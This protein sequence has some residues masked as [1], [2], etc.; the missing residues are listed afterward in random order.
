MIWRIEVAYKEW[1]E[2]PAGKRIKRRLVRDLHVDVT[3]VRIVDVYT[4]VGE[5]EDSVIELLRRDGF[6][7]PIVQ[8][9]YIN[10]PCPYI[11]DW[12]IEVGF[13][14]GVTDNV[15]RT[16]K[17]VIEA[18]SGYC[19]R[20]GEG[21]YTSRM[22]M[23]WG[24]MSEEEVVKIAEGVLANVLIQN[25]RYKNRNDYLRD[26][27]MGIYVPRLT[28]KTPP[29]VEIFDID[30]GIDNWLKMSRERTWALSEKEIEA[31]I[32]YYRKEDTKRR[33]K[34][35]GISENPSDVEI[36][37]IAQT[38]SEHCKHKIFNATIEYEEDGKRTSI[39]SIFRTFI[40][41]A[42]EEIRKRKRRDFCLSVFTDNAGVI[43]FNRK[44]N[45]AFKVETHNTPSALDPYGGA[46]TGIVGVNRDPFGT[47]K[48][49]E[50]IFNTDVFCFAP[51][52]Y[53]GSI[54][55]RLFHPKRVLEG[56]REGVEHGGNKSG[57]PTINGSITFHQNFLGKP[58]VFCGTCGIMP[59]K[60]KGEPSYEKK[61]K[62]GDLIVMVGGR[63]GKDGI[64][65]ATF[66][67]EELSESSPTSAVQ[68][69]DPI[70]QKRMTDFLLVAR[71]RGLFNSITDCGAGGLSSSV[72]EMAKDTNGCVIYLDK[73]PLKYEGLSPWEILLS[74]AQERM[75]LAVPKENIEEFLSLSTRMGVE[76]TVIGEFQ[77]TG[78]F[79]CL[80]EGKTV[81]YL[82]MDF[83]H[84]G[85]PEMKLKA[86]WERKLTDEEVPP[87]TIDLNEAVLS[88][89]KRWN[90]CSKEYVVRQYDH[91][92]KGQTV[93]KPL[94]GKQDDGPSD[95]SVIRPDPKS[96]E[97]IVV[98]HG[99]CPKFSEFD[100]YHMAACALAEALANNL[101]VGGTLKKMALLDNFC[102]PDPVESEKNPDGAYKLGQLVRAAKALYEYA[103]F[104]GTPFI[105]GKDSMKNDY[106]YGNIKISIPPTVL[107]S[108]ISIID[109]IEKCVTMDFKEPGSLIIVVGLTFP[110][111]AGTEYFS[112]RKVRGNICPKVRKRLAKKVFLSIDRAT[113][114]KLLL[115][116]HDVSDGGLASAFCESAIAGCLG[117]EID[118]SK[119]PSVSIFRDDYALF[120]E[121]P[122]RFVVTVREDDLDSVV[123]VFSGIPHAIVGKV[124]SDE[125]LIIKG[126]TGRVIVDLDTE[127]LRQA[128]KSPFNVHF[129]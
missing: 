61:A 94:V 75:T 35:M 52:D 115:S 64:H 44:Y 100:T 22:Y 37:A 17:E 111:M 59:K 118:L 105:S 5:L 31:I 49:A 32:E 121:S 85:L 57:I 81:A 90:V 51:P 33:R 66:S 102:W 3:N 77:D 87:E 120:S 106:I 80:Y 2:D 14:P 13:K 39:K 84:N 36:E 63:I 96:K 119:L 86:K 56:V 60:I 124:R 25:Y 30:M 122:S 8:E 110:E 92:V 62:N 54:P 78:I 43:S 112:M 12:V 23:I 129:E 109:D 76:S 82:H 70:T 47:G 69:G 46:L 95:G 38:W 19:F 50:L 123:K 20:E 83:L 6:C 7:D 21:V 88:V 10:E 103:T 48:G 117:A 101:A 28:F 29:K 108:A 73:P 125:R 89:L 114:M 26:R 98:S 16:A 58:L 27:G 68:I 18:I 127:T 41:K 15:G 126:L 79:H 72:G 128:W 116:C 107:I 71:D 9:A 24:K 74:E 1:V 67:S 42:T 53:E 93:I 11:G 113:K 34:E 65:G 40:V 99:I 104:F 4:V 45:L 55:P 91:E 97:A